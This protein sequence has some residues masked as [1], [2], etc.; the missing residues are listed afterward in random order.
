[1]AASKQASAPGRALRQA[2]LPGE[3]PYASVAMV[4]TTIPPSPS[5]GAPLRFAGQHS[6]DRSGLYYRDLY[7]IQVRVECRDPARPFRPIDLEGDRLPRGTSL[8]SLDPFTDDL[9]RIDGV[10]LRAGQQ[11]IGVRSDGRAPRLSD[12]SGYSGGPDARQHPKRVCFAP[13]RPSG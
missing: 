13:L 5:G 9:A 11:Q 12:L 3:A 10:K 2:V 8:L 7:S 4:C 1:M 6:L